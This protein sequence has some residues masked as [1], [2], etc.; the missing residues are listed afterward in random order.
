MKVLT[1]SS[2][3]SAVNKAIETPFSKFGF[4]CVGT[5]TETEPVAI[6]NALLGNGRITVQKQESGNTSILFPTLPLMQLALAAT[7][8]E[9]AITIVS[10]ASNAKTIEFTVEIS[11]DGSIAAGEEMTVLLDLSGIAATTDVYAI[12]SPVFG[13]NVIKYEPKIVQ[14]SVSQPLTKEFE[15]GAADFALIDLT[16]VSQITLRYA[17]GRSISYQP[18]ELRMIKN[19]I[20]DP[21]IILDGKSYFSTTSWNSISLLGAVSFSVV[22][23]GTTNLYIINEI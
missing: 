8:N 23:I 22:A 6:L 9:G 16:N 14:G 3:A 21:V 15:V 1:L 17:N 10:G 13:T 11:S 18:D 7:H 20:S 5:S 12:D 19:D 2:N 4:K